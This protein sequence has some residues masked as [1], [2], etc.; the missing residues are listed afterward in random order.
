MASGRQFLVSQMASN[1]TSAGSCRR[2]TSTMIPPM[3]Y[4]GSGIAMEGLDQLQELI[5]GMGTDIH[6]LT[7]L[8]L[9]TQRVTPTHGKG[10]G[11]GL[12]G[13]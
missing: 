5:K 10:C 9:W 11:W 3:I 1:K 7:T 12:V 2:A 6:D 13:D 8:R 4:A